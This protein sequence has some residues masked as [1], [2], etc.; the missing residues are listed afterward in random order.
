MVKQAKNLKDVD[1][2]CGSYLEMEVPPNSLIYCDPPY[3]GTT[4]YKKSFRRMD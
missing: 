1:F 2:R 4:K 3:E